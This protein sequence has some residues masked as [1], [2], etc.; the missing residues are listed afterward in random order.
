MCVSQCSRYGEDVWRRAQRLIRY[1]IFYSDNHLISCW[2]NVLYFN[3]FSLAGKRCCFSVTQ[4]YSCKLDRTK[5]L[6]MLSDKYLF[7]V[8][9][10]AITLHFSI[11]SWS[12][13]TAFNF[14][15]LR[16]NISHTVAWWPS[17]WYSHDTE[18]VLTFALT[19]IA[20]IATCFPA[21]LRGN[22]S[23]CGKK[24]NLFDV[25]N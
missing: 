20:S 1:V 2:Q 25:Y 19:I 6:V 22:S 15:S 8:K 7:F 23:L 4:I 5:W 24:S 21:Y 17:G 9:S 18:T 3:F 16:W 12:V 11:F 13:H 14:L 10:D